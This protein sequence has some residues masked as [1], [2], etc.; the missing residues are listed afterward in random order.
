M[1]FEEEL[2][3]WQTKLELATEAQESDKVLESSQKVGELEN[4][5]QNNFTR[6]EEIEEQIL[7]HATFYENELEKL[8]K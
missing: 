5:V 6:M 7:S 8:E 3:D 4:K 1:S 2:S